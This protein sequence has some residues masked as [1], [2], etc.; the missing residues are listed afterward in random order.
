M[1]E[2]QALPLETLQVI[3]VEFHARATEPG[4]TVGEPGCTV[5]I[6]SVLDEIGVLEFQL[7]TLSQRKV[8]ADTGLQCLGC[9]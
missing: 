6:I 2:A 5:Y 4:C 9:R 7:G 1:T 8:I 3:S